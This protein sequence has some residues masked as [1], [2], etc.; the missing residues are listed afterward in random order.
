MSVTGI[1]LKYT[2]DYEC[3]A[4]LENPFEKEE[5][6]SCTWYG[7]LVNE[8]SIIHGICKEC[9]KFMFY[10]QVCFSKWKRDNR[11]I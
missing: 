4:C 2:T 10:L 7:H 1:T 8:D 5:V 3:P 6:E 11:H 9:F